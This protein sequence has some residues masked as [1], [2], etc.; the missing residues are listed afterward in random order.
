MNV[1]LRLLLSLQMK[2]V[3]STASGQLRRIQELEAQLAK[4]ENT[5]AYLRMELKRADDGGATVAQEKYGSEDRCCS[6]LKKMG[7]V[8][9]MG[10]TMPQNP[11]IVGGAEIASMILGSKK[12]ES[13]RNGCTQRIRALEQKLSVGGSMPRLEQEEDNGAAEEEIPPIYGSPEAGDGSLSRA[14]GEDPPVSP[15]GSGSD[16]GSRR[17]ERGDG[18]SARSLK[19]DASSALT[20]CRHSKRVPPNMEPE[21]KLSPESFAEAET[22]SGARPFWEKSSEL[23]AGATFEE[24]GSRPSLAEAEN[25]EASDDRC[26]EDGPP[27]DKDGAPPPQLLQG[28]GDRILKYTFRR[29][30]KR[31]SPTGAEPDTRRRGTASRRS[32]RRRPP[33]PPRGASPE[34]TG[35]SSRLPVRLVRPRP[36]Y[37]L[38]S[39]S[40]K[41]W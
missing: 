13:Y 35:G 10:D 25:P 5:I 37:Q 7:P 27:A 23:V 16:G 12:A 20:R 24:E 32:R 19:R 28:A 40:E 6:P 9:L 26:D 14:E 17:P 3:E 39:L 18:G 21:S 36:T 4:A 38:I 29:K 11:S 31:G 22:V 2:D 33:P 15:V 8:G 1:E 34:T 30:R 41:R